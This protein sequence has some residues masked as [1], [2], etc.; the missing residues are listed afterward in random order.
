MRFSLG[1]VGSAGI[2]ARVQ[3]QMAKFVGDCEAISIT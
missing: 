2:A 1:S 3:N